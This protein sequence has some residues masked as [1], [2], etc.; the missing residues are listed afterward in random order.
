MPMPEPGS[1]AILSLILNN[2][3]SPW[4]RGFCAS[5]RPSMA[6]RKIYI[7]LCI[8]VL[9]RLSESWPSSLAERSSWGRWWNSPV[10]G[11]EKLL[12]RAS[13]VRQ[14]RGSHRG[15]SRASGCRSITPCYSI[16]AKLLRLSEGCGMMSWQCTYKGQRQPRWALWR[17]LPFTPGSPTARLQQL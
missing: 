4:Q 12:I 5:Q 11:T 10:Q 8:Y 13:R 14:I 17:T 1:A 9:R 7:Y 16:R 2:H 15:L 6:S 3:G